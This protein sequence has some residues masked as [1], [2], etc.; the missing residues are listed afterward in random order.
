MHDE[1][2]GAGV[3]SLRADG[4]SWADCVV[5]FEQLG[6]WCVPG[7]LVGT[8]LVGDGGISYRLVDRAEPM[9]VEHLDALD[10]LLVLDSDGAWH[11]DPRTLGADPASW[12]LDPLYPR[13]PRRVS[14]AGDPNRARRD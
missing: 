14:A 6:R 12:P 8:L 3:F 5:V 7:P 10:A 1:L 2:A 13:D 11:V 9:W 4:F